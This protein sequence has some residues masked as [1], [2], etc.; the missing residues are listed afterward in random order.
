ME[1]QYHDIVSKDQ[2]EFRDFTEHISFKMSLR[3]F[4]DGGRRPYEN[5]GLRGAGCRLTP[6]MG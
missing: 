2:G 3:Y 5:R 1:M 4:G 6:N